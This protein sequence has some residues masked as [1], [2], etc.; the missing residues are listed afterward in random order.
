[1]RI[2]LG[3]QTRV[4]WPTLHLVEGQGTILHWSH[5]GCDPDIDRKARPLPPPPKRNRSQSTSGLRSIFGFLIAGAQNSKPASIQSSTTI[6][7]QSWQ[8]RNLKKR[9]SSLM[10]STPYTLFVFQNVFVL[11]IWISRTICRL[12]APA[13]AVPTTP[14]VMCWICRD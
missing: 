10:L 3:N 1:M 12:C 6:M 2:V 11:A 9:I 7:R 4:L 5:P 8:A 14:I 13:Y